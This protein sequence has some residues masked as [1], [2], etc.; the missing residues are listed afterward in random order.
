MESNKGGRGA[1]SEKSARIVSV[2]EAQLRDHVDEK[3]RG[4]VEETLKVVSQRIA[5][6][7]FE[8]LP[9]KWG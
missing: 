9:R 7:G 1:E 2:D 5:H 4:A 6:F 8:V 3:V